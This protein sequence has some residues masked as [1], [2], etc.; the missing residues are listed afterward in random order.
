LQNREAQTKKGIYSDYFSSSAQSDTNHTEWDAIINEVDRFAA[1]NSTAASILLEADKSSSNVTFFG[2]L[3]LL[4]GTEK[5]TLEQNDWS[6]EHSLNPYTVFDKP[7]ARI[8]VTPNLGRSGRTVI[9]VTAINLTPKKPS[10]VLRCDGLVVS[11]RLGSNAAGRVMT[12]F[13]IPNATRTS[14][15]INDQLAITRIERLVQEDKSP[16]QFRITE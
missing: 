16:F 15:Q 6:E 13:T 14:L 9:T 10:I 12:N 5:I 1:P 3:A 7:T 4:P 2:S 8:E 11:G